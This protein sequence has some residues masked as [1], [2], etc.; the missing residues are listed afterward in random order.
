MPSASDVVGGMLANMGP[1]LAGGLGKAL[2]GGEPDQEDKPGSKP[3]INGP[4]IPKFKHGGIVP[5]TEK[6][7]VH[8]GE[9]VIPAEK[10][11]SAHRALHHLLHGGLHRALGVDPKD[12]LPTDKVAEAMKSSNQHVKTM[13]MLHQSMQK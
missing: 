8:K 12:P 4:G 9:L 11:H 2:T 7:I 10:V 5:K 1:G 3:G 6:A 13:A